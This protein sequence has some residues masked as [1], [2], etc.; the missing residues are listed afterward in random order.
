MSDLTENKFLLSI[1]GNIGSA[2]GN[3]NYIFFDYRFGNGRMYA[4]LYGDND[5]TDHYAYSAVLSDMNKW[6]THKLYIDL[7]NMSNNTYTVNG[8]AG[9]WVNNSGAEN[10]NFSDTLIRI[11]RNYID[12]NFGH[13]TMKNLRIRTAP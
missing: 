2:A 1:G 5:T 7:V 6:K 11:G 10:I 12:T 9:T 3:K 8:V 4:T 13:C